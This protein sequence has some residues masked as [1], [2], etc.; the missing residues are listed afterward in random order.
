[1]PGAAARLEEVLTDLGVEHDVHEY[2]DAGHSFLNR[3]RTGVALTHL[4]RIAGLAHH[5]PSA[6]DAWGRIS[7]FFATHLGEPGAG[8]VSG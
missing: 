6:E 5:H 3:H 8:P 2:P 4:E 1:M 7:R